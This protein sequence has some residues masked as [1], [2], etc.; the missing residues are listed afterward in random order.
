M[1]KTNDKST[2]IVMI[3]GWV[4]KKDRFSRKRQH[5]DIPD[6]FRDFIKTEFENPNILTPPIDMSMFSIADPVKVSKQILNQINDEVTKS[7]P[8]E[9]IIFAYSAGTVIARNILCLAWGVNKYAEI[10]ENE[11]CDWAEKIVRIILVSSITRGWSI[12]SATPAKERFFYPFLAFITKCITKLRGGSPFILKLKRNEPFVINTRLKHI[13]LENY[14]NRKTDGTSVDK[15][16]TIISILGSLDQ[17]VSPVDCIERT[18]NNKFI[19]M[20]A[21]ASDHASILEIETGDVDN[22]KR[23]TIFQQALTLSEEKLRLSEYSIHPDD[24][25][26]Y[27]D[28]LDQHSQNISQ[29]DVETVNKVVLVLHGI[30]DEGFWGKR[31]AREIKRLGGRVEVRAPAPSYGFFSMWDFIRPNKRR[32]QTLW[33]MEQYAEIKDRFHSAEISF[34]GHSN[35]TFLLKKAMQFCPAI[36]FKRLIFAGSV[37]RTD[38]NWQSVN[39]Q[40]E[41][42]VNVK[43]S[44]DRVVEFL[45]GSMEKLGLKWL[46]VGGAGFV[47]FTNGSD[48]EPNSSN[49][50]NNKQ[51][52]NVGPIIGGH[53]SALKEKYWKKI[54][55]YVVNGDLPEFDLASERKKTLKGPIAMLLGISI[56]LNLFYIVTVK[57]TLWYGGWTAAICTIIF[58]LLIRQF[59]K[60]F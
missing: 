23:K 25:N 26:D 47:G 21:P 9:I 51:V 53:S 44:N 14:L 20:E 45:P 8:D 58:I 48:Y 52:L 22:E 56:I 30:R 7:N 55:A 59:V 33:L 49:Q 31:V 38:F 40:F 17:F 54:A 41:Q 28:S 19:F 15:L 42:L 39:H 3:K 43:A 12:T 27:I 13:A 36:K 50:N 60:F 46:D 57:F 16:P 6:E 29:A 24:I 35:G 18:I 1:N 32:E 37:I 5:G 11:K 10:N 2:L 4:D 34:V